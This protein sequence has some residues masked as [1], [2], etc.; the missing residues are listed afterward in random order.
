M[1]IQNLSLWYH[2][3]VSSIDVANDL[4]Y[5]CVSIVVYNLTFSACVLFSLIRLSNLSIVMVGL[6]AYMSWQNITL[7]L[8]FIHGFYTNKVAFI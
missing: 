7:F 1:F 8:F 4:M 6:L 5:T 2:N 3:C